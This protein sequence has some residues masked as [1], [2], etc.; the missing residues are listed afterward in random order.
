MDGWMD[1]NKF[2]LLFE[3]SWDPMGAWEA[4]KNKQLIDVASPTH[5]I[6]EKWQQ[7]CT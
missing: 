3:Y 2:W 6:A 1:G 4:L 5:Q 7:A